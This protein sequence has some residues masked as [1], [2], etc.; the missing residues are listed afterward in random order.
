MTPTAL[1]VL[2]ALPLTANGKVDRAALPAPEL[3]GREAEAG[4][5]A[6]RTPAEEILAGIW[7]EV[8]GVEQV[9][10][11]DNFF[12]LGGHSL[13]ATRVISQLRGAF[14]VELGLL[15]LFEAPTVAELAARIEEALRD[16]AG[17][18]APPIEPVDREGDLPLS[19]AQQ[20]L[21]FIDRMEPGTSL[22]NVPI[23]L[24]ALGEL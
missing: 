19:F 14:Q 3:A 5:V 11:M 12:D 18:Q 1:V 15:E 7:S 4:W 8:L 9:G 13:L 24:R 20:R 6:P 16:G 10:A 2:P 23:A 21:W 22:Y 17:V